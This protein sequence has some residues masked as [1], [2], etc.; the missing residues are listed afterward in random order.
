LLFRRHSPLSKICLFEQGQLKSM[1]MERRN[2]PI[3]F[4]KVY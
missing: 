4:I 2:F 1:K 3:D